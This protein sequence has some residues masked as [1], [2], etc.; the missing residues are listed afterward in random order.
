[1]KKQ[2]KRQINQAQKERWYKNRR[3]KLD[4][5]RIKS[6]ISRITM[7]GVLPFKI[8][9][10][11]IELFINTVKSNHLPIMQAI[12]NDILERGE[13]GYINRM[14][15]V[16]RNGD[17]VSGKNIKAVYSFKKSIKENSITI[18]YRKINTIIFFFGS[19]KE[20]EIYYDAIINNRMIYDSNF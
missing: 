10:N 14:H 19:R 20:L 3:L 12:L 8:I 13:N 15:T 18:K 6:S 9:K 2:Q 16:N 7:N 11:D 17:D 4:E 1:M 5:I